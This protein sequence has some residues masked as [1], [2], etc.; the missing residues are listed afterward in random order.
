MIQTPPPMV[1]PPC[2][3]HS[4][5]TYLPSKERKA[6]LAQ[7]KPLASDR[8]PEPSDLGAF[9]LQVEEALRSIHPSLHSLYQLRAG[10]LRQLA[11]VI[12]GARG[13]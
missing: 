9:W 12:L 7:I 13:W 4:L 6:I 2:D 1:S 8:F 11:P 10:H 3:I 5:A